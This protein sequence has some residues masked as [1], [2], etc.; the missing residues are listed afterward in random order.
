M[1]RRARGGAFTLCGLLLACVAAHAQS[2]P[3]PSWNE[4]P[5][6]KKGWKR[7]FAFEP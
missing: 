3:L 5:A 2:D 4:A 7:I 1:R 6:K